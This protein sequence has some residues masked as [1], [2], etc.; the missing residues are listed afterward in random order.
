MTWIKAKSAKLRAREAEALPVRLALIERIGRCECC[1]KRFPPNMLGCHEIACGTALR[2]KALDQPYALLVVCNACH[3]VVQS[4]PKARSLARQY[5]SDSPRYDLEAFWNLR[6]RRE[7]PTQD[8][9]TAEVA[10]LLGERRTN[11]WTDGV[12]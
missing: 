5:L 9:V 2:R 8:E 1:G 6:C 4:E 3:R 10:S 12:L 11:K 7:V